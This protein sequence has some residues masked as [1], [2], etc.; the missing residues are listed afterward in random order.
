MGIF[1]S[2][3]PMRWFVSLQSMFIRGSCKPLLAKQ[4]NCPVF[5]FSKKRKEITFYIYD[6]SNAF[7]NEHAWMCVYVLI[8]PLLQWDT[9]LAGIVHFSQNGWGQNIIEN[10]ATT[11]NISENCVKSKC[12]ISFPFS[13][14]VFLFC[15]LH[16]FFLF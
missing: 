15:I 2:I 16:F 12:K 14:L 10:Y 9:G 4:K 5:C 7:Q 8:A 3:S 11:S 13:A 6:N 1:T